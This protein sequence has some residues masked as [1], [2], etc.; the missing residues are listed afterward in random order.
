MTFDI[1]FWY[2]ETFLP[3][4]RNQKEKK[5]YCNGIYTVSIPELTEA[6]FPIAFIVTDWKTVYK[7]AKNYHDFDRNENCDF[8]LF[9][10]TIRTYAGKLF[11]P[12]RVTH[13]VAIS[14]V[15]EPVSY[16]SQ[17]LQMR[18]PWNKLDEEDSNEDSI[19]VRDNLNEICQEIQKNSERYVIFNGVVWKQCGEPRYVVNTFGLGYNHGGTSMFIEDYYNPN[20]SKDA[21]FCALEKEE[22]V[23]YANRIAEA[24]GDTNDVGKFGKDIDIKVLMPECVHC[25]PKKEHGDGD[26]FMNSMESLIKAAGDPFTAGLLVIAKTAKE[27]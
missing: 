12:V 2:E 23:A 15:F 1:P 16:I 24:R 26:P 6:E 13:G 18:K 11:R 20:I 22:A 27:L 5:R 8:R 14:E 10:E 7:D 4:R 3:T 19:V 9:D 21:Y 25:N 17:Q